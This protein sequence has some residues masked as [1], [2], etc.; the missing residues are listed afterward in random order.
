MQNLVG[1]SL[2]ANGGNSVFKGDAG[3]AFA[4]KLAPTLGNGGNE[5]V[6]WMQFPCGS[7]PAREWEQFGFEGGAED[8]FASRLAPTGDG[9]LPDEE[10][11]EC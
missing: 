5:G 7:E 4:S 10:A 6:G 1:A 11:G 3:D 2:L 9:V 8:A